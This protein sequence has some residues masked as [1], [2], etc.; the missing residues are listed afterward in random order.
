MPVFYSSKEIENYILSRSKVAIFNAREKIYGV[1]RNNLERYYG[2]YKPNSYARTEQ[3]LNSLVRTDV[4][5]IGNG[6][7]AEVYFDASAL[8]Y[9]TGTWDGETVLNVSMH[10]SHGGYVPGVAIWDV[11]MSE[12]GDIISMIAESLR[13]AGIPVR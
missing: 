4:R 9:T 1:I 13:A 10:G 12:L 6:W 8:N 2:E 7:E 3:L 11:S 5:S